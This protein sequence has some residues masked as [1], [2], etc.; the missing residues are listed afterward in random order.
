MKSPRWIRVVVLLL[1]GV[2]G[3]IVAAWLLL[4]RPVAQRTIV[5]PVQAFNYGSIGNEA[6]QGLPY[7]I[8]WALPRV[9]PEYLLSPN[10]GY[11]S[12]GLYWAPNWETELP[13]GLS[14]KT[15]GVIPRV[16]VNCAFCHQ[17]SFR[18]LGE[19]HSTLVPGGA[20][21][22]VDPQAYL[23]FL[24]RVGQDRR[25]GADTIM[26]ALDGQGL[27]WWE[28]LLYRYVLI[29]ATGKA[30]KAQAVRYAWMAGRP[31]WGRG[32]IDPFN[33]VKYH[34]L[35]LPDDGTIGNSDIMPVWALEAAS[36][37]DRPHGLHWDGLNTDLF[38]VALSGAIGDGTDHDAYPRVA[39]HLARLVD[40][41][42]L[43]RPPPSPFS[44][45]RPDGDPYRVP[46]EALVQGRAL[47]R[48]HCARCHEPGGP[49][50]RTVIPVVEVQTD[51]HRL[52]MWTAAARDRYNAY[53]KGGPDWGFHAFQ[54]TEGYVA[55]EL[56]GLW[57]KGP[58]L[59]NGS[60]PTLCDLLQPPDQRPVRF[61]RGVDIV[62]P[63][64]GGFVTPREFTATQ[65]S[66]CGDALG[67]GL[68]EWG[69]AQARFV[70]PFE[71]GRPGNGN[72]GHRYGTQLEP[73][74]RRALL[75]YLKTL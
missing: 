73:A 41:I 52:D 21:T 35:G 42:R 14:R 48:E 51:R 36:R 20:G 34:N 15:V 39:A 13:V 23:R 71:V 49:R 72:G 22:R 62:D 65:H 64:N 69:V 7:W 3:L 6:E 32:R 63:V 1:A 58:Y 47:Y 67:Q 75:A 44:S 46:P 74:Q 12:L 2:G 54:K 61:F 56:M 60:V 31:D 11:G 10:D 37:K 68:L 66:D 59:H 24:A 16:S 43:Q 40:W 27:P 45:T 55:T 25:F 30:L 18:L 17:G 5:D 29:P 50:F 70:T 38:E 57:L 9:F 53:Q 28:R 26:A 33:P 19:R 8:W 4:F